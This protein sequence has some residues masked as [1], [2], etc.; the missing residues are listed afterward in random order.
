MD[1]WGRRP[2]APSTL[3]NVAVRTE[4]HGVQ[5]HCPSVSTVQLR[6][7]ITG[8]RHRR[9]FPAPPW[10]LHL[11]PSPRHL[12]LARVRST[13]S[14]RHHLS[15][16]TIHLSS[17]CTTSELVMMGATS[18]TMTSLGTRSTR[19]LS[20]W[21]RLESTILSYRSLSASAQ[22]NPAVMPVEVHSYLAAYLAGSAVV[23]C[24]F[25]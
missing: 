18:I 20:T 8:S 16:T 5:T 4:Q 13:C 2:T 22:A 17:Q 9:R 12:P 15:T 24:E 1:R 11:R 21:R 10:T 7:L 14:L 3:T 6:M 23:G 25:L 19:R